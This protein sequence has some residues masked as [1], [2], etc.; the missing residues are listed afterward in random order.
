MEQF[1]KVKSGLLHEGELLA[2]I[3]IGSGI[4]IRIETIYCCRPK[5]IVKDFFNNFY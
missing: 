3:L 5:L 1:I 4:C 2:K